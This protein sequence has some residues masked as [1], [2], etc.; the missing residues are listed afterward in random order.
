MPKINLPLQ[1]SKFRTWSRTFAERAADY[2]DVLGLTDDQ[3]QALTDV[4]AQFSSAYGEAE[5]YRNYARGK[6]A[7]KI[8]AREEA[9][10]LMRSIGKVILANDDIPIDVK[11]ELGMK[12]TVTPPSEV[13]PPSRLS[14]SAIGTTTH[15]LKWDRNGNSV[16]TTF[17][18]EMRLEQSAEWRFIGTTTKTKFTH[19]NQTPGVPVC[20]RVSSQRADKVSMP[21]NQASIYDPQ[22]LRTISIAKA[23]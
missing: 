9:E 5:I 20:Y 6:V 16:H 19:S 14:A 3:V 11:S 23:A 7:E 12:A 22:S 18:I 13:M 1:D 21:S 15:L 4:A 2:Q 17:L 10:A 8:I